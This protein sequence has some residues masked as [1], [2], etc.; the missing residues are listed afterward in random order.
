MATDC[1]TCNNLSNDFECGWCAWDS[2]CR[3]QEDCFKSEWKL[4]CHESQGKTSD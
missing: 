1:E 2:T 3:L 4:S